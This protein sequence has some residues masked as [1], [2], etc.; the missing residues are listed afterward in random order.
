VEHRNWYVPTYFTANHPAMQPFTKRMVEKLPNQ[1]HSK[2][3]QVDGYLRVEGT[4]PGTVYAIGDAS[5]VGSTR[6]FNNLT[7]DPPEHAQR[8]A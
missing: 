5:T 6:S 7:A 4:P 1:Y 8:P 2:A 3:V